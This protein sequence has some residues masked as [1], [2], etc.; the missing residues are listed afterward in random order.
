MCLCDKWDI[1]FAHSWSLAIG[2]C[3]WLFGIL[4]Q[5][6]ANFSITFLTNTGS[7]V[8]WLSW[9]GSLGELCITI[10]QYVSSANTTKCGLIHLEVMSDE[11]TQKDAIVHVDSH[12][13]GRTWFGWD[14]WEEPNHD[15]VV[16]V[17]RKIEWRTCTVVL[18]LEMCHTGMALGLS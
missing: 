4:D 18:W 9:L 14:A 2:L 8:F 7:P 5:T 11:P 1:P 12:D 10:L 16:I 13:N 3:C 17:A 6:A 15:T